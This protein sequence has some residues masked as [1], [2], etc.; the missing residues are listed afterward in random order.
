MK[1]EV[2]LNEGCNA[3]IQSKIHR[4]FIN[5]FKNNDDNIKKY[6]T[7]L[8]CSVCN[9]TPLQDIVKVHCNST[10]TVTLF[11]LSSTFQII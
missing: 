7:N 2:I 6:V 3:L 4:I 11:V 10:R 5:N 9:N 1:I 8:F